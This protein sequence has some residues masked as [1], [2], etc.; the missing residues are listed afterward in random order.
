M[1]VITRLNDNDA[2]DAFSEFER[3]TRERDR[4]CGLENKDNVPLKELSSSEGCLSDYF[5]RK[6]AAVT[7]AKGDPKKLF[8]TQHTSPVPNADAVDLCVAQ[9]HAAQIPQRLNHQSRAH[10]KRK[11]HCEL[12]HHQGIPQP[13][14]AAGF[15]DSPAFLKRFLQR[16]IRRPQSRNQS[17]EY[18]S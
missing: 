4:K 6:I 10:Q 17:K 15:T 5:D 8:G 18:A 13:H 7:A 1:G 11:R 14:A 16:D 9:I 3:W 2:R 12:R